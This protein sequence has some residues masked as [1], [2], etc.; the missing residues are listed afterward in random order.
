MDKMIEKYLSYKAQG[1]DQSSACIKLMDE[2]G[3]PFNQIG[4]ICWK[5]E[6]GKRAPSTGLYSS[7]G[8]QQSNDENF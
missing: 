5:A 1:L 4:D 2:D 6:T 7:G 3:V 8:Y